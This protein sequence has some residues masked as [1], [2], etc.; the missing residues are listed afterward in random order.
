MPYLNCKI[1][2]P[3]LRI[4]GRQHVIVIDLITKKKTTVSYPKYLIEIKLGRKLNINETIDHKDGDITNNSYDNLQILNRNDHIKMDILR[5]KETEFICP[6]CKIKFK[7]S[8]KRLSEAI[9]RSNNQGKAGPFCCRSCAGKYGTD[10]QYNNISYH[11]KNI[12]VE[13]IKLKHI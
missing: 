3:Y 6:T 7:L 10:I 11:N 9:N 5:N 2:G 12:V 1:Y 13:K 8:G 4:D